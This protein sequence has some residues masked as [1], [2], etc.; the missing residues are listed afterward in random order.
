VKSALTAAALTLLVVAPLAAGA[1][2][3]G[4]ECEVAGKVCVGTLPSSHQRVVLKSRNGS[5]VRG[6]ASVTLGWHETKVVF[7]L[8]GAPAGVRQA[9]R[10]LRGGCAGK[11]LRQLGTIVNGRGVARANELS[12]LTGFAIAVHATA[13]TRAPI[14]AC[15]VVPPA[16]P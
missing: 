3:R 2:A 14:V 16:K 8:T 1:P 13:D 5:G 6:V 10:I 9:V 4:H 7:R 12:H 11:V 15:G